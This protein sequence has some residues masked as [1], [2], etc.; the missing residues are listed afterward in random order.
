MATRPPAG[1]CSEEPALSLR[2]LGVD[3]GPLSSS[4][5][6]LDVRP[7]R[8]WCAPVVSYLARGDIE[9]GTDAQ[10]SALR[11]LVADSI[12]LD[13][14]DAGLVVIESVE[15][16]VY[17]SRISR[18]AGLAVGKALMATSRIVG[19]L[20][21]V[22]KDAGRWA[23]TCTGARARKRVFDKARTKDS[24]IK[25]AVP[26]LVRGWPARSNV[27]TRDAAVVALAAIWS[28]EGGRKTIQDL[29]RMGTL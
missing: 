26:R 17:G 29:A 23:V 27:H 3:T 15:G 4:W 20:T 1:G 22:V 21:R 14:V 6:L 11:M 12:E 19:E 16:F 28:L 5:A 13:A 24:H 9:G 7:S 18:G 25:Q 10:A 8:S 2:F